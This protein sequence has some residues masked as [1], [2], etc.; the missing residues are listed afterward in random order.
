[1]TSRRDTSANAPTA[2]L[3][4]ITILIGA[5]LVFQV[6]PIISKTILPWFG[7]SPAV[8]TTCMLFFQVLLFG[9]YAYAHLL[10]RLRPL[11]QTSI[12]LTVIFATLA[13]M[14]IAPNSAWKYHSNASPSLTILLLL[15]S[16]VGLPYFLLSSTGPLVQSWFSRRTRGGAP[17]RLYALSNIGSLAALLTYPF[18]FEPAMSTHAQSTT[19]SLTFSLFALCC[20]LCALGVW[21]LK[22]PAGQPSPVMADECGNN[23]DERTIPSLGLCASWLSLAG[24]ASVM[25]L[26]TTNHVCQDVA[27]IPFLW[28]AP[29]SLYLTTFIICFDREA[30]YSRR[31][32]GLGAVASVMGISI[33]SLL[34]VLPDLLVE[35]GLYFTAMFCICMVCHGELV[36]RKPSPEH[37]TLFYL[38]SSAGGAVGGI[39]V[40]IVCPLIFDGYVE[41]NI[42]LL[43]GYVLA[44]IVSYVGINESANKTNRAIRIA[45]VTATCIGFI[46]VARSQATALRDPSLAAIRNFYGV[47]RIK[48]DTT[49]DPTRQGRYMFHGRI[50]HGFQLRDPRRRNIP[51]MYFA[52]DSGLGVTLANYPSKGPIRVGIIGLGA[53]TI[54]AYGRP[55]DYMRFYEINPEV[56]RLA[57]EY[58]TYLEDSE[59]RVDVVIGD[60]RISMERETPQEL[61]VLVLDA[62]SGDAI[63]AH[64]LT[65]EAF[66]VYQ[67]HLRPDGVIVANISN[68]HVDLEPVLSPLA[69][70]Y[71]M[72]SLGF[73]IGADPEL[74]RS[75]SHWCVMSRNQRFLNDHVV[76]SAA[77]GDLGAYVQV[78]IWTDQYNNLFD[79]LK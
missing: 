18:L 11:W 2:W 59:A 13:V 36:R 14:P 40:A 55:D 42:V 45:C 16:T 41:M 67:R 8:W 46:A 12:H 39:L 24:L 35:I 1:M 69:H 25:L 62:F 63:P 51:T 43:I 5:F 47:L 50:A 65:M 3:Y 75:A 31:W 73:L 44:A 20:G 21:R 23:S 27:V 28:V 78:P 70:H 57:R 10:T 17:Y 54:A 30:W 64:L 48:E 61:D 52:Q 38:M 74:F 56:E 34:G 29:L 7:G 72:E 22:D 76:R 4:G 71:G 77:R 26:A 6:Q 32:F 49:D 37:L 66:E 33:I 68:R 79:L 15:A 58:F 9:G 60:A 19:W 53:G